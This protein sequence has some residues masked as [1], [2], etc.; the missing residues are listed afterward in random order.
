M[1]GVLTEDF[2]ATISR[3]YDLTICCS[4]DINNSLLDE[5][6][7]KVIRFQE[8]RFRLK[9]QKL[10]LDLETLLESKNNVSFNSRIHLLLGV[11]I[12][13]KISLK[14]VLQC[15][16]RYGLALVV[17]QFIF[18]NQQIRFLARFLSDKLS[19]LNKLNFDNKPS[20]MLI[21]S[22]GNY[23]GFENSAISIS[24]N[25]QILSILIIDNWDNLSSKSVIWN[26]PDHVLVWGEDMTQDAFKIQRIPR[27]RIIR[28]GSPRVSRGGNKQQPRL[29]ESGSILFAGSG[30]QHSDEIS[31]LLEC[32]TAL[33]ETNS[34]HRLVYRPHPYGLTPGRILRI[35]ELIKNHKNISLAFDVTDNLA[36]NFYT[37]KSFE[38]L[39]QSIDNAD[40]IIG[41][42]S[43][44]LVEALVH[45]RQVIAYSMAEFG[46][47]RGSSV[48]D[49][50]V[51]LSRLRLNGNVCEAHSR[52]EFLDLVTQFIPNPRPENLAPEIIHEDEL[53]YSERLL[54]ALK[55][56][57]S[58]LD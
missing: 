49:N 55:L 13:S 11:S 52:R 6:P 18:Q 22:G 12:R 40:F 58:N 33:S 43:T 4:S 20:A 47:F 34:N 7:Y 53:T 32:S 37:K 51:H 19:K 26:R 50:Y 25:K 16:S 38:S 21:F 46:V 44:V 15:R 3:E 30:L 56:V 41:T 10:V 57:I 31:L 24:D 1:S 39:S 29:K 48:W 28:I 27:E 2:L 35:N 9:I 36:E 17:M 54:N 8:S 5:L 45:G 14:T 42:H 23:S